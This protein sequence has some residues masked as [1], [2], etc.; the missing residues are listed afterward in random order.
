[1]REFNLD[2]LN[3]EKVAV[4]CKTKE[5][6]NEILNYLRN[7]DIK[8]G[9]MYENFD[10]DIYED[11]TCFSLNRNKEII[12]WDYF[13]Y[14]SFKYKILSLEDLVIKD[15]KTVNKRSV[16]DYNIGDLVNNFKEYGFEADFKGEISF[17][18]QSYYIGYVLEDGKKL[19]RYWTKNLVC[20]NPLATSWQKAELFNSD[21]KYNLKPIKKEWYE[22]VKNIGK[23]LRAINKDTQL[24]ELCI[25]KFKGDDSITATGLD[26]KDFIGFFSTF[27]PATKEEV[28]SLL[29]EK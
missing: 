29:V 28:L 13:L 27:R 25:F 6:L 24:D 16:N 15:K 1:M 2:L 18:S 12:F 22:D 21:H 17:E 23:V 8:F 4:N 10:F 11:E 19:P 26:G 9:D 5:E 7:V 14:K 3:D 20:F